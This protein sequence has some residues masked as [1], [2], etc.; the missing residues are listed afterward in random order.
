MMVTNGNLPAG[1]RIAR[2]DEFLKR[3]ERKI[4]VDDSSSYSCVGVRWYGLGAFIR[5]NQLGMNIARKQQWIIKTGDVVYNK[6]FAWK[7]SF[8]IADESVDSCIVSDKFPTYEANRDLIVLQFLRYYFQTPRIAQQAQDLSKGA[9][10]ISKLTLNPPQFWDLT[11]PLPPLSEQQRII[12]RIEALAR[13]VEE[14]RGLRRAAVEQA[15]AVMP[16][17]LQNHFRP[18]DPNSVELRELLDLVYGDGLKSS[19]RDGGSIPVFGSNG[20]VGSHSIANSKGETIV[21][22]RKG[23]WGEV[24]YSPSDCWVIDTAFKVVPRRQD[25]VKYLY[26][27]LK[28]ILKS[29]IVVRNTAKPGINRGEYLKIW[30]RYHPISDQHYIVA[31]LDGLQAK[32]DELRRLQAATQKELD[33]LMPSILAKAFAGEL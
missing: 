4:T 32:V 10:A 31:Y 9:A 13:R 15:E 33:A 21:V 2:F 24:N 6:L 14:A 23:S 26:Y 20:I 25:N 3:V 5:E 18:S 27:L 28:S 16:T 8:A 22:G 7:G 19:Q 1:W 30:R 17:A 29:E 11:I 12:A